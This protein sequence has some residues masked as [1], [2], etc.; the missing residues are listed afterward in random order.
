VAGVALAWALA[1]AVAWPFIADSAFVR[2]R[3]MDMTPIHARIV[4]T[5]TAL[6]MVAH[7]PLLGYGFGRYTYDSGKWD[8]VV[9]A[10]GLSSQLAYGTGVPHNEYLH[11]LVLLGLVGFVPY[12]LILILAWRTAARH[13]RE[14][15]AGVSGSRRD[16]ALV[17]LSVIS[18][19]L[20]TLC[21]ADAL[22]LG[23]A[24]VQVYALLGALDGLRVR[25]PGHDR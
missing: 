7:R 24:S 21:A 17:F 4:T 15:F 11:V 10:F 2:L 18:Q 23:P 8:Y 13:Y 19:F 22:F 9:G 12:A 16:I 5:A 14:G 1:L 3:V 25:G 20:T 6:N